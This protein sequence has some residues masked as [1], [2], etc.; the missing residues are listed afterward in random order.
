MK[1]DPLGMV[2][3]DH[4]APE[5]ERLVKK[6]LS[7]FSDCSVLD[8]ACGYGRFA[9]VFSPDK[10]LGIDFSE[11]MVALGKERNPDYKFKQ[12]DVRSEEIPEKFDVVMSVISLSSLQMTAQE[13]LER[14]KRN[15]KKFVVCCEKDEFFIFPIYDNR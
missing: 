12:I 8:V 1:A 13:F 4:E 2:L 9:S 6:V 3:Y 5:H 14:F 11:A 10:Y 15:A 7:A